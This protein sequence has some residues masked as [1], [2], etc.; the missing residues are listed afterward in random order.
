L[1]TYNRLIMTYGYK[2]TTWDQW[3]LNGWTKITKDILPP[4]NIPVWLWDNERIWIGMRVIIEDGT[5]LWANTYMNVFYDKDKRQWNSYDAETDDDY[6][7]VKF[8]F[9]PNPPIE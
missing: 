4:M 1:E 5:W 7:P 2:S 3:E 6:K 8:K 9:L